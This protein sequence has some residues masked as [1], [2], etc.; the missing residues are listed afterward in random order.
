MTRVL[1]TK[2]KKKKKKVPLVQVINGIPIPLHPTSVH[3]S[4]SIV[5]E[6]RTKAKLERATEEVYS[7]HL[8]HNKRYLR[9][10]KRRLLFG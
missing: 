3:E 7:E 1:V 2:L 4:E 9:L 8:D 5:I 6:T 10:S